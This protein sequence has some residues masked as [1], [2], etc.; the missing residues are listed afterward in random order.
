MLAPNCAA[1]HCFWLKAVSRTDS[2]ATRLRSHAAQNAYEQKIT[3]CLSNYPSRHILRKDAR[4]VD[5]SHA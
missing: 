5:A 2:K 1:S 3:A 4:Q